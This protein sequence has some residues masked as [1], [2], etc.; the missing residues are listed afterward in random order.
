MDADIIRDAK[1]YRRLQVLGCAVMDT[2]HL[3][4]GT[5]VRFTGLDKIVDDDLCVVPSRGEAA[6]L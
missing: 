4:N 6:P 2:P 5:V 1:R 3:E